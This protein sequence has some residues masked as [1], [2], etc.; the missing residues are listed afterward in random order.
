[1]IKTPGLSDGTKPGSETVTDIIEN[2]PLACKIE[3][4]GRRIPMYLHL[5]YAHN[6]PQKEGNPQDTNTSPIKSENFY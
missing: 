5:N 3:T 6:L 1:M 4:Y 2:C